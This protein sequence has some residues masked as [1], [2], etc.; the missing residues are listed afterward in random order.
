MKQMFVRAS[1]VLERR[2]E[3]NLT[4]E[5]GYVLHYGSLLLAAA[6]L[7]HQSDHVPC[8]VGPGTA[9]QSVG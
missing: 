5:G 9:S 7:I 4:A 6:A 3:H 2:L 1:V 8:L